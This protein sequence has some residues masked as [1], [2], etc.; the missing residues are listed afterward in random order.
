MSFVFDISV[1]QAHLNQD[2]SRH[3]GPDLSSI[4]LKH[5]SSKMK[6]EDI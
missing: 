3:N 2:G 1:E 5:D 6:P 4:N